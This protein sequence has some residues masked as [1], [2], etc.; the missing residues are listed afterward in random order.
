MCEQ[1][2]CI[3]TE[4]Y[5]KINLRKALGH[6]NPSTLARAQRPS[7]SHWNAFP[8]TSKVSNCSG[9]AETSLLL[10]VLPT[11]LKSQASLLSL[12]FIHISVLLFKLFHVDC[13]TDGAE[14]NAE[15]GLLFE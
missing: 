10:G 5:L 12:P 7:A 8:R 4:A 2:V 3:F 6:H 15:G 14:R 13:G 11:H 1:L 9:A